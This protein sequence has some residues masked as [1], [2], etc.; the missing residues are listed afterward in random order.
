M[1]ALITGIAGQDGYHLAEYLLSQNYHVIGIDIRP[2]YDAPGKIEYYSGSITDGDFLCDLIIKTK[3]DAIFN[4]ASISQVSKCYDLPIE[5]F[6]TNLLPAIR[7]LELIRRQLPKT[8]FLQAAS[9]DMFGGGSSRPFN[10]GSPIDP[11]SIYAVSKASAYHCVRI[12]RNVYNIFA[13]NAILFNHTSPRH[14]PDFV[15]A[16][17]VKG[18]VA[19][20][21]GKEAKLQVGN[22]DIERDWGYAGDYAIAMAKII[23][24]DGADDYVVGTGWRISLK[25]ILEYVLKALDLNYNEV[26]EVNP[27]YFRP[28]DPKVIYSDPAK[29]KRKLGW[30]PSLSIE[31]VLDKM[32]ENE[33][34]KQ[35]SANE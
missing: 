26:I 11:M 35:R 24:H 5:T 10:E 6:T 13:C 27:E 31:K 32:L 7:I 8:R 28:N 9:S 20:K 16:K 22:L 14:S 19:I 33:M 12:Y 29:I 1:K 3:P 18:L 17:I 15:I 34:I 21:L 2:T 23:Q 25:A 30:A 4:L